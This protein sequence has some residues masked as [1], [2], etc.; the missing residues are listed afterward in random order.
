MKA[1]VSLLLII[2]S[3]SS[4]AQKIHFTDTSNEWDIVYV[5]VG[6]PTPEYSYS[7]D[8]YQKDTI[9]GSISY[10][11]FSGIGWVREDTVRNLVYLLN[12]STDSEIVFMDYNLVVGDTVRHGAFTH[13]VDSLDSTLI[14]GLWYKV[15]HFLPLS[16]DTWDYHIVEGIGCVENPY[17]IL[18]PV[19]PEAYWDV[20]CFSNRGTPPPL[21]P[22]VMV[23]NNTTSCSLPNT[24][25]SSEIT[26][27]SIFLKVFP[28]PATTLLTVSLTN[29]P[30]NQITIMNILG[31]TAYTNNYNSPQVQIDISSLPTGLYFI[32]VNGSEM[33]KF[34]KE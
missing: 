19:E 1:I 15:W 20:Y 32:K 17:F 25:F 4:S 10:S 7:V 8:A 30:I 14:N 2:C 9:I 33:R 21:S 3:L 27:L 5:F 12:T 16:A 6:D 28:N 26:E 13:V 23:L 24:L 22:S 29:Q 31:Q 34:V 18:N 11:Y